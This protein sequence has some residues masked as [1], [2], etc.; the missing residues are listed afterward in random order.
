[1]LRTRCR[2]DTGGIVASIPGD[3]A[4][5]METSSVAFL[6][7]IDIIMN[8]DSGLKCAAAMT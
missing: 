6:T 7:V 4:F 3:R 1:M 8:R 5:R 2:V